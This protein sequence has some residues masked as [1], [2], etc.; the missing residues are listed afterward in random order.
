MKYSTKAAEDPQDLHI[1]FTDLHK[2]AD[3]HTGRAYITDHVTSADVDKRRSLP[4]TTSGKSTGK[5]HPPCQV[6]RYRPF[7]AGL[8]AG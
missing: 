1:V 8:L 4:P 7:R 5:K 6:L 3:P 2:E